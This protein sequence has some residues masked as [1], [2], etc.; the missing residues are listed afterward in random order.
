MYN[1]ILASGLLILLLG[2]AAIDSAANEDLLRLTQDGRYWSYNGGNY[3]NWR[4]SGMYQINNKNIGSLEAAWSVATGSLQGQGGSPLVLPA[5]E[6]GLSGLTLYIHTPFPDEVLAVNL[7]NQRFSWIYESEQTRDSLY[8]QCCSFRTRGLA[9]ADGKLFLEQADNRLLALEA[10]SGNRLWATES[11]DGP[12][13]MVTTLPVPVR[14]YLIAG[15]NT[16]GRSGIT[17]YNIN[18]GKQVW[19]AFN[20]GTD[21]DTRVDAQT[22]FIGGRSLDTVSAVT[23]RF[24]NDQTTPG[25]ATGLAAWDPQQN[26]I[27]YAG[28]T[29]LSRDTVTGRSLYAMTLFARD[30]ETGRAKWIYRLTPD[31][32][33]YYR[34]PGEMIL[35]DI[36]QEGEQLPAVVH[37]SS[38]GFVYIINRIS[39]ELIQAVKFDPSVNWASAINLDTGVPV[40]YEEEGNTRDVVCP[41]PIGAR[42]EQPASFS[43]R[44][45]LFYVPVRHTCMGYRLVTG[46]SNQD[47]NGGTQSTPQVETFL[48]PAG[49]VLKDGTAHMGML[50]AWDVTNTRPVW[51][52][53]EQWPVMSGVLA[54]A[55]DVVFYGTLDG[56]LKAVDARTGK[57]LWQF[58]VPSG[59]IGDISTWSYKDKQFIG[60]LSGSGDTSALLGG[61]ETLNVPVRKGGVFTAFSLP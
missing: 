36:T 50:V 59:V 16:L 13:G 6:T 56:Y 49:T 11:V 54:T 4:Y 7:E 41:S 5:A 31:E 25:S 58:R 38:D 43:P 18:T 45:G 33:S 44:T 55:G 35:A 2:T 9:Y 52:V 61:D 46:A 14:N 15:F 23:G 21:A 53:P 40:R 3:N 20:S 32:G 51:S 27:Y 10:R 8:R 37:F 12:P 39:G 24:D 17:A 30:V 47:L 29:P 19:R 57:Y 34:D 28:T 42:G 48:L 60:V 22:R 1:R 26:L